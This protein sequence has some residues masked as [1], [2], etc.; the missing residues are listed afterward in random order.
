MGSSQIT[1]TFFGGPDEKDCCVLGFILGT[2]E[3]AIYTAY[4]LTKPAT[5]NGLGKRSE[6]Q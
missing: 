1:C 4:I 6:A 2:W 3:T 5:S